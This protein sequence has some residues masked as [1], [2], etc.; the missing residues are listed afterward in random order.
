MSTS[1]KAFKGGYRFKNFKG[2]P[3]DTI[4]NVDAPDTVTIPLQQGFGEAAEATVKPGDA[5]KA[6]QIIGKNPDVV[7]SPVHSSV[8]GKVTELTKI[9][10]GGREIPAVIIEKDGDFS[11]T[12]DSIQRLNGHDKDWRR[13]Q[14]DRVV[15]LIYQSG[16]ASLDTSG[17]PTPFGSSPV[18]PGDIGH[19]IVNA[20]ADDI[21]A[22]SPSVLLEGESLGRFAEGCG[23]LKKV[24]PRAE[25]TI[26]VSKNEKALAKKLQEATTDLQ[27]VDVAVVS[28]K[29]P[30]GFDEVLVPTILGG[31]FPYGFEAVNIGVNVVSVQTVLH[32]FDAVTEGIPVLSRL[33]ALGGSGFLENIYIRVPVGTPGSVI[34]ENYGKNDG[35]YRIVCDSLMHGPAIEDTSLPVTRTCSAVYAIPEAR[36]TEMMSFASPGFTKDSYTNAF[37]TTV[38]PFPK[39]L[40]T[41]IHGEERACLS[42][43][44]CEEVCPVGIQPNLIHRYV[45]RELIDETIQQFGIFNCIDCNLCTYVCPSKIP[46]AELMR[47]GKAMLRDE[48]LNDDDKTSSE[49]ALKG[50]E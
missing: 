29:Y 34:I 45:K 50:I 24:M 38:L 44:Y 30:Q 41:N 8:T 15:E 33:I 32:V 13:L 2:A 12:P 47:K 7:S 28:D 42:C 48:G 37:P 19:V 39:K 23:I 11:L 1:K 26:A 6:G 3:L 22:V 36:S 17:I 20:V 9:S 46:V 31:A 40:D 25:V 10:A 18:E 4:V 27:G 14:A 43:S 5:V 49:F 21:L 35:E 16:A